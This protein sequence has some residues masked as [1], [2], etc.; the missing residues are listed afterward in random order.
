MAMKFKVGLLADA[1][2]S[3][4]YLKPGDRCPSSGQAVDAAP[5]STCKCSA[6]STRCKVTKARRL[7]VH[8]VAP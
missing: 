6:C 1:L 8:R 2:G 5:G 3:L 4:G 7:P